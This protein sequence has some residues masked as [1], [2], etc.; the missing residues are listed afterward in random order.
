MAFRVISKLLKYFN[1]AAIVVFFRIPLAWFGVGW[2]TVFP[3]NL[4]LYLKDLKLLVLTISALKLVAS[5]LEK[6]HKLPVVFKNNLNYILL[7]CTLA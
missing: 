7:N 6:N 3:N 4:A 1:G 2:T 5:S